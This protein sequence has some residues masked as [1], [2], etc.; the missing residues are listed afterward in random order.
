MTRVGLCE[1]CRHARTTGNRRGS[2]FYLCG[3]AADD[4]AF[5]KYPVLPVLR[6]RGYDTRTPRRD[7]S[8]P[9]EK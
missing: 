1:T 6:C 4:P 2:V 3:R 9:E 7:P 8:L 5:P